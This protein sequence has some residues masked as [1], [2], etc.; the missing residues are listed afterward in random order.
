MENNY[1]SNH[2]SHTTRLLNACQL[3][4]LMLKKETCVS[5]T[6]KNWLYWLHCWKLVWYMQSMHAVLCGWFKGPSLM[7]KSWC[8]RAPGASTHRCG[9]RPLALRD[10]SCTPSADES[11]RK[12]RSLKKPPSRLFLSCTFLPLPFFS[13][14]LL[15]E[16]SPHHRWGRG[17]DAVKLSLMGEVGSVHCRWR[18]SAH[19]DLWTPQGSQASVQQNS[20]IQLSIITAWWFPK[21]ERPWVVLT[22]RFK[23]RSIS[24]Q[25]TT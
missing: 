11:R 20:C 6:E 15:R 19:G 2:I 22:I 3:L 16:L 14:S 1:H 24:R 4:Y 7:E 8:L 23:F 12:A 10:C 9:I 13:I 18:L 21:H 25:D 5:V 17:R